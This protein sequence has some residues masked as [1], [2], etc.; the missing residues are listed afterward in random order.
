MTKNNQIRSVL[1]GIIA[2]LFIVLTASVSM[3]VTA[4]AANEEIDSID[5]TPQQNYTG[6][7]MTLSTNADAMTSKDAD[8]TVARAYNAGEVVLLVEEDDDWY[9]IYYDNTLLYISKAAKNGT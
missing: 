2:A 5:Y 6:V 7:L 9:T 4:Y 3:G 8:A 1:T